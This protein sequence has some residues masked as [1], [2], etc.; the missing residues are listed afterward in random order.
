MK[1]MFVYGVCPA[2]VFYTEKIKEGF[3]G[4]AK[5]CRVKIRPKYRD[6]RGLLEHELTHVKQWYRTL[7][8]HPVLYKFCAKYR[9]RSEVEAYRVQ[10]RFYPK[11]RQVAL[12]NHFAEAIASKYRLNVSVGRAFALLNK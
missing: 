6:D 3:G 11:S 1:S 5:W 8:L 7:F 4:V 9:L 12:K 10:L 2:F